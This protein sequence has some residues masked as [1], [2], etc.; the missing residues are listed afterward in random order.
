MNKLIRS[1]SYLNNKGN[2]IMSKSKLEKINADKD[3]RNKIAEKQDFKC[4]NIPKFNSTNELNKLY[5]SVCPL[6]KNKNGSFNNNDFIIDTIIDS[7]AYIFNDRIINLQAL[8]PYCY[9]YKIKYNSLRDNRLRLIKTCGSEPNKFKKNMATKLGKSNGI[10][11]FPEFMQNDMNKYINEFK[12]IPLK[13]AQTL[14]RIILGYDLKVK[15]SLILTRF[16]HDLITNKRDFNITPKIKYS[17]ADY[18]FNREEFVDIL[19]NLSNE[20]LILICNF[21]DPKFDTQ[22]V[23]IKEYIANMCLGRA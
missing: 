19:S 3:L 9:N 5:E 8:C 2:K 15:N 10:D 20:I 17:F 4:N 22:N 21:I 18:A 6:W 1:D 23:D 11:Q 13:E 16:V 12:K 7:D 14:S